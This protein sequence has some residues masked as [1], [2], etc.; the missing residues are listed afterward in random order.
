MTHSFSNSTNLSSSL[1]RRALWFIALLLSPLLVNAQTAITGW[2]LSNSN[3]ADSTGYTPTITFQ[4]QTNAITN[5]VAG[6]TKTIDSTASSTFVRRNTTAGNND[7]SAIWEVQG[8]STTNL[9][10]TNIS[11]QSITA[12]LSGN[13]ALMGVNDVFSNGS[14]QNYE[15][16]IERLDFYW[17]GG[18]TAVSDQGFAVFDRGQASLTGHD[19]FQIV[20]FTGWDTSTN[21]PTT[22]SGNMLKVNQSSYGSSNLDW[23]PT[24]AGT[25]STF[26]NYRILRF[27][28]GDN[29][30]PLDANSNGNTNQGVAGVFISFADLGIAQGTTVYGYSLMATDVNTTLAGLVDWTNTS[31]YLTNTSDTIGSI[32]LLSLNGRRFVPEPATYGAMLIAAVAA[33]IGWRRRQPALVRVKA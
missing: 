31:A 27:N 25:Q 33:A 13:N 18:F 32:D 12:A 5:I 7:R 17:A 19:T 20:V 29:L 22:Y 21:A 15:S 30:T 28:S 23:D 4:N 2:T 24:T 26:A 6:T 16:N 3:A 11:G 8:T 9:M 14:S 10:G 1:P